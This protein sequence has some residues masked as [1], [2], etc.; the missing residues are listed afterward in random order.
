M[1]LFFA[2]VS[3]SLLLSTLTGLYM[4]WRF[5]R[6]PRLI[7]SLLLAGLLVPALLSLL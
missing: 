6:R 4:A 3:L 2:L 1:K 7:A 5:S